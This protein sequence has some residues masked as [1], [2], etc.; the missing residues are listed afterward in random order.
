MEI[1]PLE[2]NSIEIDPFP[3]TGFILVILLENDL[4]MALKLSGMLNTAQ[5]KEMNVQQIIYAMELFSWGFCCFLM[6]RQLV[7][8]SKINAPVP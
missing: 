8:A 6:L 4:I 5:L 3:H 7:V 2:E 1:R